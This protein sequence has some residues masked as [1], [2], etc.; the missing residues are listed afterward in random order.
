MAP[1]TRPTVAL[2]VAALVA[3]SAGCGSSPNGPPGRVDAGAGEVGDAPPETGPA[4]LDMDLGLGCPASY[5]GRV[6]GTPCFSIPPPCDYP[7][8]R[9]GCLFCGLDGNGFSFAWS[10]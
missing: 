10:C 8:G 4:V 3:W 1:A 9:C 7:E 5:A 6:E 2:A